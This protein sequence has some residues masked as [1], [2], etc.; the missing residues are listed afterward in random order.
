LKKGEPV[1]FE[2]TS[3]DRL[4]GFNI[5]DMSVHAE[6][7]PNEI[8]RV[9]IVPVKAGTFT[10]FCDIYCGEGHEDMNGQIIVED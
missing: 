3:M 9:R 8:T 10:F 5:P 1:V 6:I 7:K 2:L 4:H